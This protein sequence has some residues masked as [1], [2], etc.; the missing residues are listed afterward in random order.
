[1]VEIV[2]VDRAD[3]VEA[4]LLEEGAAGPEA[5]R[6]FLGA[7]GLL[8]EEFRQALGEL[9]RRLAQGPVGAAGDEPGEI[10]RHRPG[11]RRDRHVVVVED[12]D[13]ARMPGAG[14]VHRLVGHARRHRSVA[15]DADD[16]VVLLL[17]VARHGHAETGRDR[18]RG[19]RRPE[20][21][22]L[23]LRP[24]REA[25]QARR[26][27]AGCGCGRAGRSGS[28]ADRPGGRHRRS[29]GR[30]ACRKG[31]AARPSA[32]PRQGPRRDARRSPRPP[33]SSLPAIP[34]PP[35]EG[36]LPRDGGDRRAS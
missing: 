22:V 36:P 10:G 26:P 12:D 9:L 20:G 34:P 31:S 35:P 6:E 7:L 25:G 33:R 2:P 23:A 11:R 19:M 29:A 3:I 21:V 16:G 4:Q 14:I 1:M 32:R 30:G 5:A 27:G 8:V 28:C 24:L 15:D 17:E 13:E 18:G